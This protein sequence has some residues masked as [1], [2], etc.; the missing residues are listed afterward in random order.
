MYFL[1]RHKYIFILVFLCLI[2][3]FADSVPRAQ[4]P[5]AAKPFYDGLVSRRNRFI[6]QMVGYELYESAFVV[7][8]DYGNRLGVVFT[9]SSKAISALCRFVDFA[10]Q[11]LDVCIY[12]L[13]SKRVVS[14]LVRAAQRG[15]SIRIITESDNFASPFLDVLRDRGIEIAEDLS[16]NLMHN[17]FAVADGKRVWTGSFNFT[18]RAAKSNDNNALLF[19][20]PELAAIYADKFVKMWT[21]LFAGKTS[22]LKHVNSCVVGGS[23]VSVWFAP[24][25]DVER[26]ICMLLESARKSVDV[27]AFSFT[28][29]QICD[30]LIELSKKG[31]KVRCLFDRVMSASKYS[32]D[33]KLANAG[34]EVLISPNTSGRMHNKTIVIDHTT[35]LTGSYNFSKNA[36]NGNAENVVVIKNR[37]LARLFDWEFTRCTTGV[38]GY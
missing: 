37:K 29:T 30:K 22:T 2:I 9:P 16:G 34:V 1:K 4:I 27:M 32:L 35:V 31:V 23:G 10:H 8:L 33:E 24:E 5:D 11:S 12:Q 17:K 13:D 28:S 7:D 6:R 25:D 36:A 26:H 14:S 15:V 20:S 21:E 3:V 19:E 18:N 38:K